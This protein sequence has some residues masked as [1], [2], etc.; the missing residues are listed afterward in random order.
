MQKDWHFKDDTS[1]CLFRTVGVLIRNKKILVQCDHDVYALPGGHVKVGESSEQSLIREYKEET[2]ADILCDR[3][4]WTEE[5]FWE[6]G[7]IKTHGIIFYYLISLRN[8]NEI[9]DNCFLSQ[10]DNCN[11]ELMWV[12][13]DEME[14]LEIYP[15]FIKEKIKSINDGIEHI[16]SYE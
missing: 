9:P 8:D 1:I 13:F 6:W 15:S 4:I 11:I 2:G 5:T 3:L 16:I 14:S 12:T 7:S 10:K